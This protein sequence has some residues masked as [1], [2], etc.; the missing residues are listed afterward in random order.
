MASLRFTYSEGG[1][2]LLV[3]EYLQPT[4]MARNGFVTCGLFSAASYRFVFM[5]PCWRSD[6][7]VVPQEMKFEH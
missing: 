5:S 6:S 2:L 7:F 3:D 4:N 1:V